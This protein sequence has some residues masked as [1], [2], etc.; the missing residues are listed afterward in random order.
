MHL[1]LYFIMES[2]IMNPDQTI[3]TW[4]GKK[5]HGNMNYL[6]KTGPGVIKLFMLNSDEHENDTAHKC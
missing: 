5:K 3:F 6:L 1:E 2:D 4:L